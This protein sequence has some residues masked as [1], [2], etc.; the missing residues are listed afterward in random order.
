ML[1]GGFNIGIKSSC[2]EITQGGKTF[3]FLLMYAIKCLILS[4]VTMGYASAFSAKINGIGNAHTLFVGCLDAI[5]EEQLGNFIL[6]VANA[7]KLSTV[8]AIFSALALLTMVI[9]IVVWRCTFDSSQSIFTWSPPDDLKYND[10]PITVN[11]GNQVELGV[12][13]PANARLQVELGVYDKNMGNLGG[14]LNVGG[15]EEG[16]SYGIGTGVAP[17]V[18][19]GGNA[20]ESSDSK[21]F[22]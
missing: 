9:E 3:P 22:N 15:S 16:L 14:G 17:A 21:F 20:A 7:Q 13:D 5:A 1:W 12:Y 4:V 19:F 11:A 18:N 6:N 2:F 8:G 10:I